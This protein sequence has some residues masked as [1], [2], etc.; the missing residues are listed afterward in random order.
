[1]DGISWNL[2]CVWLGTWS[3][4]RVSSIIEKVLPFD[5]LIPYILMFFSVLSHTLVLDGISWNWY[6]VLRSLCGCAPEVLSGCNQ[7]EELLPFVSY[8]LTIFICPQPYLKKQWFELCD[9][10]RRMGEYIE[11]GAE[12]SI[13]VGIHFF[14]SV[15]FLLNQ[16]MEFYQ[17][18]PW[19]NFQGHGH[20]GMSKI[21]FPCYLLN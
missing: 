18:W 8:I 11:I 16:L 21:W 20:Y 9:P 6:R 5:S 15:N 17:F 10:T 12:L 3:F 14:V 1:M 13:G 7:V 2:C 19:P 4:I